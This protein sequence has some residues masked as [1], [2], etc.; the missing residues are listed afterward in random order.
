MQSPE[1]SI[2]QQRNQTLVNGIA[3][4]VGT[5]VPS[6]GTVTNGLYLYY[7]YVMR[8]ALLN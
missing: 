5:T 4:G 2:P 1:T 7:F 8:H 6:L 3:S